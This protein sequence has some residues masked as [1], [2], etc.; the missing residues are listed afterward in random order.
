[1]ENPEGNVDGIHT[2]NRDGKEVKMFT[3]NIH[4]GTAVRYTLEKV[5]RKTP[6]QR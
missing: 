1:M 2:F 5:H 4:Q 3:I 6:Y